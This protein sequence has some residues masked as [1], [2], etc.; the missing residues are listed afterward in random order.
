MHV[1]ST[2]GFIPEQDDPEAGVCEL[3]S[4]VIVLSREL[5]PQEVRL[6]G[7]VPGHHR[8]LAF[9]GARVEPEQELQVVVSNGAK[10]DEG[11][12]GSVADRLE[13]GRNE[14]RMPVLLIA[15]LRLV[16]SPSSI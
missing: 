7:L 11:A 1:E 9:A 2:D 15:V 10:G 12:H 5:A 8:H 6:P 16:E 4:V 14:R 13:D 3:L